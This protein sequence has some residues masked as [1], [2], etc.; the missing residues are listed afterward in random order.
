[1]E[2]TEAKRLLAEALASLD[3]KIDENDLSQQVADLV[4]RVAEVREKEE[5]E[6]V[7][8]K[9]QQAELQK[10]QSLLL[11]SLAE[12]AAEAERARR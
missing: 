2:A 10:E 7:E 9:Q 6:N 5:S 8:L 3:V 4:N 11:S 1:M 12:A